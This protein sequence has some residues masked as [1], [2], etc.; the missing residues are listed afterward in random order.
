M[1]KQRLPPEVLSINEEDMQGLMEV[2]HGLT[3][4]NLDLILHLPGGSAEATEA[5]VYYIRSKFSHVR[6]IVPNQAMS[7]ATML[8]CSADK[9]VMGKHSFLGPIDPQ[10]YVRTQLGGQA[11]PAQAI[12]DQFDMAKRDCQ[13]PKLLGAWAPMLPQYGP[14]LLVQCQ[15][16][17]NLSKELVAKWLKRYMFKSRKDSQEMAEAVASSLADHTRF[18]THGRPID[19]DHARSLG[20]DIDDLETDQELQDLVLSVFHAT[21]HT[22]NNSGAVKI[23]ENHLGRA[24][25]KT[26]TLVGAPTQPPVQPPG[27]PPAATP[28]TPARP[29]PPP[30]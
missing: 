27:Q 26:I 6:V 21:T 24:F 3:S 2:F 8:A 25:V 19:R 29:A 17:L 18:K 10:F 13:D 1:Q 23:I 22:F 4:D 12:L 7:A 11:V 9:I 14:A 20:L 5:V 28:Q 15:E 16:S 30:A